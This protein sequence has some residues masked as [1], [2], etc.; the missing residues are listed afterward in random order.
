MSRDDCARLKADDVDPARR[1]I[2]RWPRAHLPQIAPAF[3]ETAHTPL[4]TGNDQDER[5]R[6]ATRAWLLTEQ[7][8][9]HLGGSRRE[10]IRN[11]FR[12][13]TST[14]IDPAGSADRTAIPPDR[15][16]I[17]TLRGYLA[18]IVV[19]SEDAIASKNLDG[20]VTSWNE[21][22]ERLFGYTANEMIGQSILRI[23]PPDLQHEEA[24]IL[25]KLRVGERVDRF[26]TV[27]LRKD[28]S[29]VEIS[30]TVSPIRDATGKVIGAAKIA[31]DI[32]ARR[33]AE[34]ALADEARALETL[35]GLG[36][37][38]ASQLDLDSIVQKVTDAATELTGA[39]FGAFFY[40]VVRE[41][42]ES[43]WLYT[44]SGASRDA[45]ARFPL[46]RNTAVFA[47]TFNG[48]GV[49]RS[50][51]I[52]KDPRYGQNEPHFGMPPGHLP[53]CSYLAVPV[54]SH[55]GRVIGG[56][57][58]GH[59]QPDIFSERAERLVVGIALQ[60]GI[61]IENA[62]LFK[63][64]VDR[65][66]QLNAA[67]ED[68]EKLLESERSARAAAERL[69]HLKDEFLAT[70]SHELRTPL[71]AIQGWA[72]LLRR[73]EAS[74]E[75]L[76]K[77]LETI[78]RNVRA[79]SQLINDLLDMSRIISG[80]LHLEVQPIVLHE[81][82]QR[83]I[84]TV[85]QSAAG[86][87]IRIRTLLDSSIGVVRGDPHRLQQVLW[88][89]LSNAVKFTPQDGRIQVVLERVNSHVE[90]VIEDSGIGIR[91]EFLPHVFDRFRQG[92]PSMSRKFGGLGLGLSIVKNLVEL[93]GGS[94]RVK[95]RGENQGSTF[96]VALPISYVQEDTALSN[97][98][99]VSVPALDALE[100]PSLPG[101]EVLIVDDD[102][103]GRALIARILEGRGAHP[104]CAINAAAALDL[105]RE[106]QF[107]ILLS[108]IGMPQ[109][110][111][112]RFI[113]EVRASSSPQAR[114]PAIAITAYA[115]S[116]DRQR[117]LLSGYQMHLSKPIE[118]REL[119]A[120]IASL[121]QLSS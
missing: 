67:A 29:P 102:P 63:T 35:N 64:I 106:R 110:D 120:A 76:Q 99:D 107:N 10:A 66:S 43:Y 27:R 9:L 90:I 45:F 85:R 49:V 39:E 15:D 42:E 77:G 87:R 8:L 25:Q 94:V 119:L 100:L 1:D 69:S 109:I 61:A 117:S 98:P 24:S 121:L 55:T 47:P 91:P 34:Q 83:A 60:A 118:A 57:F 95:S 12:D 3:H 89:L 17:E 14:P 93:H 68:R 101:I 65:E 105:L 115:R 38:I 44:L 50:A 18:A 97:Q 72:T 37:A 116:E 53:V 5:Y 58:F 46:P 92:D 82:I 28:G 81:L 32:S 2:P 7:N 54:V 114:I 22:A 30:L 104:T 56:L 31:H 80:N 11:G 23:I 86:K 71:N 16:E 74:Q 6:V 108:D 79:Q 52:R 51:D 111:G 40:N 62:G 4:H 19:S 13:L 70:L 36:R 96:I 48:E 21:A 75:D 20:I 73:P 113:R 41:G 33:R 112:Y 26:E 78:E 84:D 59:P 88:N 103:D